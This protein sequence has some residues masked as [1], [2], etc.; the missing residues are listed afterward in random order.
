MIY[1]NQLITLA[2]CGTML[3]SAN[4]MAAADDAQLARG[5]YLARAGDCVACHTAP[6]GKDFAGGLPLESP[7]G[8]IY[9]TN[10]TPDLKHGIG[11]Y[12]RDDFAS[13]LRE[14]IRADGAKLY[15]A[16]PYPSYANVT[17]EDIDALYAYFMEGV[18]A[19]DSQ[20]PENDVG[21]PYNQRWGITAWN[22]MFAD[23]E[24]FQPDPEQSDAAN[25][26][27]YLV[28][29][30]AHC[31]SCHTPRGL[32]FQEK[33]LDSSEGDYLSGEVLG[34]WLAPNIRAGGEG[35]H[36]LQSWS[37]QDIVDYLATGRNDH[38]AVVGE[39]SSVIAHSTSH[40]NEDDLLS[41]AAYLQALPREADEDRQSASSPEDTEALLTS[42]ELGDDL[43][44]RLYLDNCNACHL[45]NGRGAPQ[46]FPSLVD[47]SLVNAE[48]PTG[49]IH[50][51]LAGARLPSTPNKPEE[52]AMP[53]FGWRLSDD[54]A[55]EL[56]TFV[57]SAWGNHG[58]TVAADQVSEVRSELP[59]D[60]ITSEPVIED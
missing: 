22:W 35:G 43:G 14:G 16:M 10:I 18:E 53:D 55:A 39:M 42:A 29:G 24:L 1:R 32:L 3:F 7:L 59:E 13:A 48:D 46:V 17:D 6:G 12:S 26:G 58:S 11:A 44:A 4:S 50:V 52:L 38:N 51:I 45:A 15:P 41:I 33:A 34:G 27:A 5:E 2:A 54:E 47:N 19:D 49:L 28:Q 37:E 40:L 30:L 60:R 21:F 36:G 8:V 31:G 56:A 25:R 9:S 57:R 23:G 20:P